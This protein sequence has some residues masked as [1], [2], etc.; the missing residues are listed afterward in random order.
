VG[1]LQGKNKALLFNKLWRLGD[2]NPGVWQEVINK[3]YK[4]SYVNGLPFSIFHYKKKGF[5]PLL[6]QVQKCQLS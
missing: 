3:K 6:T 1:S 2:S 4:P 5:V